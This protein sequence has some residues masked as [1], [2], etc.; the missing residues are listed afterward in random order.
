MKKSLSQFLL[1]GLLLLPS[2]VFAQDTFVIQPLASTNIVGDSL[3][4]TLMQVA[5]TNY[6][7]LT[8]RWFYNGV[9][10]SYTARINVFD[11]FGTLTLRDVV[12]GDAGS[13]SAQIFVDGF[14]LKSL[15]AA[16]Y[17]IDVP[18]L[19]SIRQ[20]TSGPGI[21][22]VAEA[23]GGLLSYQ[24][25][26]QGQ[27]IPGA[28]AR[29]LFFANAYT[30]ANAGYYGVSVTNLL[31]A[32]AS[33]PPGFLL[34]KPAL[35]GTYQ[36]L[37]YDT[38]SFAEGSSGFFEFT[39]SGSK[40]TFSGKI[41]SGRD[42]Y[43]FSGKFS[44]AQ[45]AEVIVPRKGKGSLQ[46]HL[47]LVSTNDNMRCFGTLTDGFWNA[48]WMGRMNYYSSRNLTALAGRY[49][50]AFMNTNTAA[51][52]PNG[53]G[54]AAIVVN[55][56]GRVTFSGRTAEGTAISQSCN[57]AKA[58]EWPLWANVDRGR[59][60]LLGW[61]R[62]NRQVNPTVSGDR[63]WWS[64]S[65][66]G[67]SLYPEGYFLP[68][69]AAGSPWNPANNAALLGFTSGV[70]SFY[71]GD[72]VTNGIPLWD[73]LAVSGSRGTSFSAPK[74]PERVSFAI[75]RSTGVLSGSLVNPLTGAKLRIQGVGLPQQNAA[76]GYFLGREGSGYFSLT[77]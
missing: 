27:P 4:L 8:Y 33:T 52:A 10:L 6:P 56:S 7:A 34:A 36:G 19:Q 39:V 76:R 64:K 42:K 31:G 63:L 74:T 2:V 14:L 58:G 47:Q 29:T 53:N 40:Q 48:E 45:T 65:P 54:Y 13:Y 69:K 25:T 43:S 50:V 62:L 3:Q 66:G 28:T 30:D 57:L 20:E 44:L 51:G 35:A 32:V 71:G 16:V 61:M 41:R 12:P 26:W 5:D 37:F 18:V 68:V 59:Q 21:R 55:Q 60:Q 1:G 38:N 9:P 17:V 22:L 24:W 23:T 11:S 49:T 67:A 70:A 46:L 15:S 72:L 75:K 77:P 73:S